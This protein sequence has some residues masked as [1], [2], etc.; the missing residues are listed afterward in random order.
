MRG[1]FISLLTVL[2]VGTISIAFAGKSPESL[3]RQF[4]WGAVPGTWTGH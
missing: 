1:N 2:A 3:E 4:I